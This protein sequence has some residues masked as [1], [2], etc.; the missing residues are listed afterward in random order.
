MSK[1]ESAILIEPGMIKKLFGQKR[2]IKVDDTGLIVV[3]IKG[4]RYGYQLYDHLFIQHKN[5]RVIVRFEEENLDEVCIYDFEHDNFIAS[6]KQM[7]CWTKDNPDAYYRHI[8]KVRK[9]VRL[10]GDSKS[11]DDEL[12]SEKPNGLPDFSRLLNAKIISNG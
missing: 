1:P 9:I 2:V 7:L 12:F 6:V 4:E 5:S 3:N 11:Q 10:I 8:G